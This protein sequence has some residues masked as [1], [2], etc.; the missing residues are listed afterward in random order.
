[1]ILV[2]L[3]TLPFA[4]GLLAWVLGRR[5]VRLARWTSLVAMAGGL[6]LTIVLWISSAHD[7]S[8]TGGGPWLEQVKWTW[9]PQAG[10]SFQLGLDG[11]SLLLVALCYLLGMLAVVVSWREIHDRVGFFH[12]HLLW[13]ISGLVGVFLA[14]DLFL[15]YFLFE[16]MLV[17]MY[18]LILLW[19]HERRVYSAIKFF[20]FTQV[21]G[22]FMLVAI[23]ALYFL[24]ARAT[25]TYTFDYFQLLNTPLA[26]GTAMWIMLG[27]F[28]A[29]AV[30]L[31]AL[32]LHTWLPDAHTEAPTAGSLV[33]A[34]LLIKVG[35]YGMLRFQVPLFPQAAHTFAPVA[36]WLGVAGIIYGAIL[37]F[38]Q[39]DLKRLVAY[40]SVSHMGFVLLGIFAWNQRALQGVVLE[41]VCHA[42][43]TGG[44][45]V[46]A[47]QIQER[48]GTRQLGK[49]GGSWTSSP[50]M[51]TTALIL[52]MA[53]LGLP[54]LGNFVAEF[55]ILVGSFTVNTP[56]VCVAALGLIAAV[57]YATWIIQRVFHGG[58]ARLMKDLS[59]RELATMVA[60]IAPLLLLG[61]YPAPVLDTSR[62]AVQGLQKEAQRAPS[63]ALV[64]PSGAR[65][66]TAPGAAGAAGIKV[67]AQCA[68][69]GARD[70]PAATIAG[71]R[72]A[73]APWSA[74]ASSAAPTTPAAARPVDTTF[75]GRPEAAP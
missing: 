30:K 12:F 70:A 6:L 28:A 54:G 67:S 31:P 13:S 55:L 72:V 11:L 20:I 4:A 49:L 16:V 61:F 52:A 56:A 64:R 27:F 1:V 7:L 40:T 71:A 24:H 41:I 18:F 62:S 38:A 48:T 33:L 35:A 73:G 3:L 5:D 44:L 60:L 46:L 22:L 34:G 51:G 68:R 21:G 36:M 2:V 9:I 8:V 25:G 66:A 59:G 63:S 19:G 15:F 74:A 47:G 23:L 50:T 69:A 57:V 53:S 26:S 10:I 32:P 42:L 45:F 39:T 58:P 14:L 29:F 75:A 17:P 37:A 43:S 65:A